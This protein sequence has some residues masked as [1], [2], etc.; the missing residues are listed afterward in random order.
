VAFEYGTIPFVET[1]QALRADQW[2]MNHPDADVALRTPIKRQIRDAFY[3]DADD[4][5]AAVYA[6]ARAGCLAALTNLGA[7]ND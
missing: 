3:C 5:K 6:Q 2:L 1:L 4:W 7:P